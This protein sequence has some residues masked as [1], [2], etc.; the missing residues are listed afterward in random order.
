MTT[1]D[2]WFDAAVRFKSVSHLCDII[3]RDN[4]LHPEIRTAAMAASTDLLKLAITIQAHCHK[5]EALTYAPATIAAIRSGLILSD[6]A[7]HG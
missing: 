2:E 5:V 6:G 3:V 4:Q 1:K 7:D